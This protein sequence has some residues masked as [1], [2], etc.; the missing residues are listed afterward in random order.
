MDKERRFIEEFALYFEKTGWLRMH[1]RILAWLLIC[2][3]PHQSFND[4]V[5]ILQTSKSA[6]STSTRQ[7]IRAGFIERI[8]FPGQRRD[9]YRLCPEFCSKSF[10]YFVGRMEGLGKLTERGLKLLEGASPECS[11]R[12][13]EAHDIFM[14]ISREMPILLDQWKKRFQEKNAAVR[15]TPAKH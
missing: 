2:D 6:V 12:L 1:G 3:P 8:S 14:F 9:F 15:I 5:A 10:G 13:E 4:L 11:K 7:L